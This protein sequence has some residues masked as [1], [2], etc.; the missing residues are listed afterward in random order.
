M[1]LS[2]T[3]LFGFFTMEH[4]RT[5]ESHDMSEELHRLR[6]ENHRA[7]AQLLAANKQLLKHEAELTRVEEGR[8]R[9]LENELQGDWQGKRDDDAYD[10]SL[11]GA[12][13]EAEEGEQPAVADDANFDSKGD[14]ELSTA[15]PSVLASLCR[16]L[17][18]EYWTYEVC[19]GGSV[20][21]FHQLKEGGS[22][23][24]YKLGTF[25]ATLSST[26]AH[27]YERGDKCQGKNPGHPARR[28]SKVT[29]SCVSDATEVELRHVHEPSE[30]KYSF[31][32]AIPAGICKRDAALMTLPVNKLPGHANAP[33]SPVSGIAPATALQSAAAA[34]RPASQSGV[35]PTDIYKLATVGTDAVNQKREAVINALRHAW[36][37]YEKYAWGADELKP[38]TKGKKDWIGLGL[39][40]LDSLDVLMLAGLDAELERGLEWVRTSLDFNKQRSVSFFETVIRC[41]GGLISAYELTGKKHAFLLD[42]AIDL[43][44]RL[45]KAFKG[46]AGMPSSSIS[47]ASGASNIPSWLGGNVLLA[48]VGTVQLEFFSLAR[49]SKR[50][51]FHQ[52]AQRP[53]DALDENGGPVDPVKGRMWPIHIRP[54]SGKPSG[55][56]YTWGAMGDSYYEYLL[57]MW[58]L[59]GKTVPQYKRMYLESVKGLIASL[60]QKEG[61]HSYISEMKYTNVEKKMDHLVCFV[62]GT[63]AL[64]AQHLPEH[65]EEHMKIAAGLMDTCYQMYAQQKTGLAPEF[66]RFSK[67]KM[68]VGAGHNLLRPETVESIFYMWRFTKDPKYREMGWKIFIAFEKHCR[69]STGGYSGIKSVNDDKMRY[70]DTMQTFWLAESLK[71][72]LLLFSDDSALNLETHVFNTEAHPIE[73]FVPDHQAAKQ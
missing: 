66:V 11:D 17:T 14:D 25:D 71:Y 22:D 20:R 35:G 70:D 67:G 30:C 44:E 36:G 37:G 50:P 69:I 73:V 65:K 46:N 45:G 41:L 58:L 8:R 3:F 42:K 40:I 31:S 59:T 16:Q 47:L 29:L 9:V 43:G 64:G 53:I 48:E 19:I 24:S 52:M 15:V 7:S 68:L 10:D 55:A 72:F 39:T 51:E 60:L 6:A 2:A 33:A 54:D 23:D 12:E 4:T 61:E 63:L 21:Q 26:G 18:W 32:L 57:K 28:M 13:G 27:I 5:N 49:H 34:K 1:I 38:I 56:V 62:P